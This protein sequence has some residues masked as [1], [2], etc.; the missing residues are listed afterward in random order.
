MYLSYKVVF[1]EM[2]KHTSLTASSMSS[3][4]KQSSNS[5]LTNSSKSLD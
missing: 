5:A 3:L 2:V 4:L 1:S